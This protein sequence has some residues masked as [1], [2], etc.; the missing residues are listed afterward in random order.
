MAAPMLG[1]PPRRRSMRLPLPV[2]FVVGQA[3]LMLSFVD[4]DHIARA[5]VEFPRLARP[6]DRIHQ[7]TQC[8]MPD[9]DCAH[10]H[11]NSYAL[12]G[13]LNSHRKTGLTCADL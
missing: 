4:V 8:C 5:R 7:R 1:I 3:P 11:R 13:R 6:T 2:S 12:S 10:M 9:L